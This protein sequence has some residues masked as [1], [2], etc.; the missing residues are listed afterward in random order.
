[1]VPATVMNLSA[2]DSS[3]GIF[4]LL[5]YFFKKEAIK[6]SVLAFFSALFP[7]MIQWENIKH[8]I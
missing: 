5:E 4:V 1:M 2:S 7:N 6:I 3:K 8:A